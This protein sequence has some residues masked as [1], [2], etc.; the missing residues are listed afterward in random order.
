MEKVSVDTVIRVKQRIETMGDQEATS[1]SERMTREQPHVTAYLMSV[2]DNMLNSDE[3][4]ALLYLGTAVWLMLS[5]GKLALPVV[6]EEKLKKSYDAVYR[7]VRNLDQKKKA[8]FTR[9]IM[10]LFNDFPQPEI[11]RFIM[12]TLMEKGGEGD[13]VREVNKGFIMLFLKTLMDSFND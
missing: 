7:H 6:S 10:E 4:Q 2:G 8:A 3:R 12:E 9:G 5:E 13:F 1:V 11:L